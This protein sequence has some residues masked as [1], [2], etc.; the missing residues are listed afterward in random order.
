MD[1]LVTA[2]EAL[3]VNALFLVKISKQNGGGVVYAQYILSQ[4]SPKKYIHVMGLST[5]G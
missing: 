2:L 1:V 4:S 3:K 5:L